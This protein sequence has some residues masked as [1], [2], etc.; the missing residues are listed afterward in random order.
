MKKIALYLWGIWLCIIG[1]S[2]APVSAAAN[3][4]EVGYDIQ[5]VLP[6]NQIDKNNTYFDL[7][8]TPGQEQTITLLINNTSSED[9][10]FQ[11]KINQAYTN[12]QGFIDYADEKE[13]AKN[14]YPYSLADIATVEPTV[15]VKKQSS[16]Q[17]PIQLKM[18]KESFNGQIL[19][20]IQVLKDSGENDSGITNSYGYVLGLKLTETDV[21]VKR[22]LQ[23]KKVAAAASFGKTSVVAT[24]ENPTM[25]AIGHLQYQAVITDAKSNKEVRKVAYDNDMQIAPNAKYDFA[26]DWDNKRLEPG[27]YKLHLE[28]KDAKENLWVFD[29]KFSI[30]TKEANHINAITVDAAKQQN[31]PLWV[32]ILIGIL[33]ALLLLAVIWFILFK[34]RKKD[35][36]TA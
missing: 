6:T 15:T 22:E 30:S 12:K 2:L 35:Q 27:T 18:P 20:A 34:R 11:V 17:L 21:V 10:T 3:E 32:L 7:R 8:M 14:K 33:L 5:A 19:G 28:V 9:T 31:L 26:I 16:L 36:Q 4:G 24:L 1:L 23:L 29:E 25:D 13:A